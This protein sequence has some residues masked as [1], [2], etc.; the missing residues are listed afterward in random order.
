M[1][2]RINWLVECQKIYE[3]ASAYLRNLSAMIELYFWPTYNGW[4]ITI[5]LEELGLDYKIIPVDIMSGQQFDPEF[6]NISPNNRI[7]ALID[8]GLKSEEPIAIFESGAILLYLAEKHHR[9]ISDKPRLRSQTL[10]WLFF[11]VAN[12]G[13]MLGQCHHFLN[14]ATEQIPYAVDRYVNEASRLFRVVNQRL[15]DRT[16][17]VDEY[18][19]ADIATLPWLRNWE[20]QG[21]DIRNFPNIEAWLDRLHQRPA[22]QRGLA[23]MAAQE[24]QGIAADYDEKERSILWGDRQYNS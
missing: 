7:P 10:Q 23:I 16:F 19:I 18:S 11:Q 13:P 15:Q 17:L 4:K 6:L 22:V 9:L 14:Y 2:R 1:V 12:V 8:H 20:N 24:R 21:Q 3:D 5:L